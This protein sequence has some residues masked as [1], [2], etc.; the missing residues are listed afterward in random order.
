MARMP[1]PSRLSSLISSTSFPLNIS[2]I[3][4]SPESGVLSPS[5]VGD[6]S[7]GTMGIFAPAL[8]KV[9]T[10]GDS[11]FDTDYDLLVTDASGKESARTRF[12]RSIA[13][14]PTLL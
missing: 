5:G 1:K 11:S 9:V 4:C 6:F 12:G 8:T 7:T 2:P 14:E 3:L 10:L 13:E